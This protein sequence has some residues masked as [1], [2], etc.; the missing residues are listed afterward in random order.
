SGLSSPRGLAF[1]HA[2]NL[3][4]ANFGNNTIEK[5]TP[6]GIGSVFASSGLSGPVGL[7]FDSAGNLFVANQS[8]GTIE[9]FTPDGVG[10]VFARTG[11]LRPG[12]IAIIPEPSS[13][14]ILSLGAASMLV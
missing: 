10:S 3:Y 4:A 1:D 7:A 12:Y 13:C 11:L 8:N 9:E 2:G 5:F 14:L 6:G